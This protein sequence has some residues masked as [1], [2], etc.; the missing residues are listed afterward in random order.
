VSSVCCLERVI[1]IMLFSVDRVSCLSRN[2]I[3]NCGM[4]QI[5]KTY[6]QNI[7]HICFSMRSG[8]VKIT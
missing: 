8:A 6:K 3:L 5:N 4:C 7:S 1:S 2:V